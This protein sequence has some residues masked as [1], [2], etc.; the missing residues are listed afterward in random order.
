MCRRS[1]ARMSNWPRVSPC[2]PNAV[3]TLS[4]RCWASTIT[5]TDNPK[6]VGIEVRP[7]LT[8][9]GDV[10]VVDRIGALDVARVHDRKFKAESLSCAVKILDGEILRK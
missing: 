10:E 4:S 3:P 7:R 5:R 2:C 8:P 9:R 6:R 1:V